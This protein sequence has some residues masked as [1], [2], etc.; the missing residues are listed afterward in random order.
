[1][2]KVSFYFSLIVVGGRGGWEERGL[3]YEFKIG[4]EN[5]AQLWDLY[6]LINSS[7][8]SYFLTGA[9]AELPKLVSKAGFLV[10]YWSKRLPGAPE[11]E[12]EPEIIIELYMLVELNDESWFLSF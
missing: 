5:D 8:L 9:F 12:L 11:F 10:R 3:E 2:E 1:M 6:R 7:A 4:V